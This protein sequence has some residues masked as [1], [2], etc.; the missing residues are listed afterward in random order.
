MRKGPNIFE[1]LYVPAI[2]LGAGDTQ[3]NETDMIF[4]LSQS[5]QLPGR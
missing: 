1:T 4:S 2:V 3:V 5:L